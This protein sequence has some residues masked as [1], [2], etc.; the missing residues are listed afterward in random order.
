MLLTALKGD[1]DAMTLVYQL[2]ELAHAWDDLIDGDKPVTAGQV[3]RAFM[4]AMFDIQVNPF[5]ARFVSQLMPVLRSAT[6]AWLAAN[7]LEKSPSLHAREV[8]H[9]ARYELA[10]V[11]V[12]MAACIGGMDHAAEVAPEILLRTQRNH[13]SDYLAELEKRHGPA[14]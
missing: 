12:M 13:L 1:R 3:N 7:E 11:Y 2:K 10:N 6:L 9:V 5:Y 8:A 4:L 14:S